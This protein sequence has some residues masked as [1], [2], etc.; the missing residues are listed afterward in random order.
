MFIN[1]Q[2][3]K[4]R[5]LMNLETGDNPA[6]NCLAGQ[7]KHLSQ[8]MFQCKDTYLSEEKEENSGIL[9]TSEYY[10]EIL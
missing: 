7:Y 2:Y 3:W 5:N 9:D 10:S 1:D 4:I 6:W 8:V